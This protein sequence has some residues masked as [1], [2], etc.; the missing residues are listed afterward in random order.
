MLQPLLQ[1]AR[2]CFKAQIGESGYRCQV[3]KAPCMFLD[4]DGDCEALYQ[5]R[6]WHLCLHSFQSSQHSSVWGGEGTLLGK[7]KA[8]N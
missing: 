6:L 3:A 5:Q 1:G 8:W 2:V 7:V 4:D